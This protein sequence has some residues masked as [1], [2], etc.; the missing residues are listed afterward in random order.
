VLAGAGHHKV[1][2]Q[3]FIQVRRHNRVNVLKVRSMVVQ[4]GSLQELGTTMLPCRRSAMEVAKCEEQ[5]RYRPAS[6]GDAEIQV[7]R[8]ATLE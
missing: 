4:S 8:A 1:A 5:K 2:L 3:S 6:G 7:P